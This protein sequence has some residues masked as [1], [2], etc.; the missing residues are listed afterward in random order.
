MEPAIAVIDNEVLVFQ[1]ELWLGRIV[2]GVGAGNRETSLEPRSHRTV[3]DRAGEAA[4]AYTLEFPIPTRG[5]RQP[6]FEIDSRNAGRLRYTLD[7]TEGGHVLELLPIRS[8]EGTRGLELS[9]R[10]CRIGQLQPDQARAG[11]RPRLRWDKQRGSK[12]RR[13]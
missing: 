4:I 1:P 6:H 12:E 3:G 10:D 2:S 8:G 13:S 5:Q 7:L 9:E 11:R